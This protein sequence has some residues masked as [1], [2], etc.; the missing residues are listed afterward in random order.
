AELARR[1]VAYIT[2]AHLFYRGIAT[3]AP[4]LPFLPDALYNRIFC[5]PRKGLTH[6][7]RAA[8]RAMYEQRILVDVSHMRADALSETFALLDELD[9][10]HDADPANFPVIASHAGYRFGNQAYMLDRHT[11]E[12]IARRDGVIGLIL[13]RHQLQDGLG[14]GDGIA[15]TAATIEAHVREIHSITGSNAF[16]GIGSDLDGFIKP[17]MSA[18]E[19]SE[20]LA[21]LERPLRDAFPDDADAILCGNAMRVVRRVLSQRP[22]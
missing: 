7:G 6:L 10:E 18:I 22:V 9:R 20:D 2:L 19:A 1:G 14:D 13:A 3:N 5:Q 4:A 17:T 11:I 12:Q 8:V 16:T 21:A 15:H